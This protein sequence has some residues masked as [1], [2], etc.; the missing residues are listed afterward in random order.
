MTRAS[1]FKTRHNEIAP[2]V[3]LRKAA[4]IRVCWCNKQ[5]RQYSTYAGKKKGKV[6]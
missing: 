4:I 2:V 1:D 5:L 6:S 3:L